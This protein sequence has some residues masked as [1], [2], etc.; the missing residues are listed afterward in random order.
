MKAVIITIGSEIVSGRIVDTNSAWLSAELGKLGL[1]VV[2]HLSLPD[3]YP[4][5][6]SEIQNAIENGRLVIVTGGIGPTDDDLTRQAVS[7]ALVQPLVMDEDDLARL[8][9][10]Y[11][12]RD[13]EFPDGSER[14]CSRPEGSTLVR[15]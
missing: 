4:V 13:W 14:Q 9:T 2:R 5:L 7:E 8:N 15:N 6:V 12:N 10:F 1:D 11:Q 3:D